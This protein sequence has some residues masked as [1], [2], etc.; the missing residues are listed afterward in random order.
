MSVE[1]DFA[2]GENVVQ[3]EYLLWW[4]ADTFVEF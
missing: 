1:H 2:A 3:R 4:G